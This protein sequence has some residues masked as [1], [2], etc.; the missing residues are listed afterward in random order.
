MTERRFYVGADIGGTFTDV[1][2]MDEDGVGQMFKLP[3]TPED[4]S[5]GVL[6]CLGLAAAHFGLAPGEFTRQVAYFAHGTTAATNALIERSGA[7]TALLT[8]RG[9]CDSLLIQRG[10]AS[11]ASA[12]DAPGTTA[13]GGG[14]TR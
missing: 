12:G 6:D 7:P 2:V 5:Q 13:R 8:T 11:W 3:T 4:R 10:T 14:R 9:A 1:I